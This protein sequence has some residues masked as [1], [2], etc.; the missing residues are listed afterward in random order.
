[1]QQVFSPLISAARDRLQEEKASHRALIANRYGESA[2]TAFDR[3]SDLD[4][5]V[6]MKSFYEQRSVELEW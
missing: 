5:P 4:L 6:T 2:D 3:V 1:M